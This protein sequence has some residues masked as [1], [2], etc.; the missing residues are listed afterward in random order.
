MLDGSESFHR[1][2][3]RLTVNAVHGL[4]PIVAQDGTIVQAGTVAQDGTIVQAGTVAQDGTIVQAGTVALGEWLD[5]S[6]SA[7]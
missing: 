1:E 2:R 7:W 4:L 5:V 6:V 3:D